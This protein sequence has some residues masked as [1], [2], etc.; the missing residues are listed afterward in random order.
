MEYPLC[1]AFL[2]PK[3]QRQR[4][5]VTYLYF[6]LK[7]ISGYLYLHISDSLTI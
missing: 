7:P 4:K 6:Y 2:Y 5:L 1:G 3:A